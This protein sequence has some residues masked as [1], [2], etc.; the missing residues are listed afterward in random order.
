MIYFI[1]PG[2]EDIIKIE[3]DKELDLEECEM[4]FLDN[5]LYLYGHG[6]D[7]FKN[8]VKVLNMQTFQVKTIC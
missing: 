5:N 6:K 3:L 8:Y 2:S 1:S 4:T 7:A